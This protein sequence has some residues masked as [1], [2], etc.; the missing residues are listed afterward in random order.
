MT[1]M[2]TFINGDGIGQEVIPAARQVVESL[3]L[4]LEFRQA[5]AGFGTFEK[6]GNALPPETLALCQ[7]SDAVLFGAT[8]SPMT[9]TPGYQSP[10]L[11]LRR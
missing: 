6:T 5:E 3:G 7:Q 8:G 1:R 4:P 11:A 2:I 10:I 9:K